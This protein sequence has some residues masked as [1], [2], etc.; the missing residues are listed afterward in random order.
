M[1]GFLLDEKGDI[2]IENGQL[3]M[4]SGNELKAQTL[5]TVMG[6]NKGEWFYNNDEGI[7]FS[8]MLGKGI[9]D[10][11]RLA[12]CK[13]ACSQ[14]DES[15]YVSE[16][17]C[18][19]ENKTRKSTIQFVAKND[20]NT[21]I[22]FSEVYGDETNTDAARKLAEAN[23]ELTAYRSATNKLARRLDGEI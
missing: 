7:D 12:Q 20:N 9:T 17:N 8:F 11:M 13:D 6:T 15:L 10:E 18:E 3:V 1:K 2:V 21:E 16:F 22:T 4:I 14:V 5:R 19:V 23:A